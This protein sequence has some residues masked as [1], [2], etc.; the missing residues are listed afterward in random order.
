MA[1]YDVPLACACAL[2]F[3]A[4]QLKGQLSATMRVR[5]MAEMAERMARLIIDELNPGYRW[6]QGCGNIA[7]DMDSE[8]THLCVECWNT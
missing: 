8:N 3:A 4:E 2:G 7:T 6:C 5:I 1:D